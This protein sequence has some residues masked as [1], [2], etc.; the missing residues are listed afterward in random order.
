MLKVTPP[1]QAGFS[2]YDATSTSTMG[3]SYKLYNVLRKKV[4]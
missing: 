4:Y 1:P 2:T 3:V